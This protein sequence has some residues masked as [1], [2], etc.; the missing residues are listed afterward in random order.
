LSTISEQSLAGSNLSPSVEEP[1]KNQGLVLIIRAATRTL[2]TS[3]HAKE[4]NSFKIHGTIQVLQLSI[5]FYAQF[6]SEI[7]PS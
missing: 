1:A 4:N 2:E 5:Q 3:D 6:I 7:I